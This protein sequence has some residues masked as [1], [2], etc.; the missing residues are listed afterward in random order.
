MY[1]RVGKDDKGRYI[2]VGTSGHVT[3]EIQMPIQKNG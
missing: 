2:L 1:T 3:Y